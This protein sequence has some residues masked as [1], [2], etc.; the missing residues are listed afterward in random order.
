MCFLLSF[1]TVKGELPKKLS[2]DKS[3]GVFP[4][5]FDLIVN[6]LSSVMVPTS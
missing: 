4:F 2:K 5:D 3:N 6:L 1:I